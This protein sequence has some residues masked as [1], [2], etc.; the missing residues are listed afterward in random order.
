MKKIL[1]VFIMAVLGFVSTGCSQQPER[2]I[3]QSIIEEGEVLSIDNLKT[4]GVIYVLFEGDKTT[5][6]GVIEVDVDEDI[7]YTQIGVG[8]T[9]IYC[10]DEKWTDADLIAIFKDEEKVKAKE[11]TIIDLAFYDMSGELDRDSASEVALFYLYTEPDTPWL[12]WDCVTYLLL[13]DERLFC[14]GVQE[15]G[16]EVHDV[17]VEREL[18][19]CK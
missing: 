11:Q 19:E 16:Y 17:D 12:E 6:P 9:A 18:A 2:N 8:D 7:I 4:G 13:V 15:K 10:R 3:E 5:P 1:L 14:V